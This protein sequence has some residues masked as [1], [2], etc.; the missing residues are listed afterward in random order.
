ML[1]KNYFYITRELR[2]IEGL[3]MKQEWPYVLIVNAWS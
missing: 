2:Q 1:S 3:Y